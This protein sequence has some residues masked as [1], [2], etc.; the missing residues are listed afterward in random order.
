MHLSLNFIFLNQKQELRAGWKFV[1]YVVFFLAFWIATGLMLSF[2]VARIEIPDSQFVLAAIAL[3]Q[4]ALFVPAI[5]AMWMTV[6]FAD[7]R[8]FRAFGIGFVPGWRRRLLL[9]F[10]IAAGML[11]AVMAG[12][13][14]F[15]YVSIH[16]TAG[17][18]PASTLAATFGIIIIAALNEELVFRGFPLQI[19]MEAV[20]KWPGIILLSGLFGALHVSNPNASVVGIVNTIVAGILLSLAYVKTRSLWFPYAIHVGWNAGLGF[21]FGF[22]LSGLDIASLWTT[23]IAGSE[24]ILGGDYGPEG[25]LLATFIFAASAVLVNRETIKES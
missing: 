20:G 4:I 9:G 3:N 5:A 7:H 23:G 11:S 21:I 19:M 10:L 15:G 8:L 25:G 6:R 16:W 22:R 13:Y 1:L 14:M 18:V 2:F 17:Q 12:C 24:T